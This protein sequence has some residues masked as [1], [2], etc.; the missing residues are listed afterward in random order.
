MI[1]HM[2]DVDCFC[3]FCIPCASPRMRWNT[4]TI[5]VPLERGVFVD[6]I[7]HPCSTL[8]VQR[9]AKLSRNDIF[10]NMAQF[11]IFRPSIQERRNKPIEM[12]FG[13]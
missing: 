8:F 11:G 6:Y 10:E 2:Q 4:K 7:V 5:L 3:I 1:S 13:R 9:W 12:K